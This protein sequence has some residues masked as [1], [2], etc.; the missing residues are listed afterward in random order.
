MR[1]YEKPPIKADWLF[2]IC[3]ASISLM[4]FSYRAAIVSALSLF[5]YLAINRLIFK[6]TVTM[7]LAIGY[8]L[9]STLVMLAAS[10]GSIH[11][12]YVLKYL[13]ISTLFWLLLAYLPAIGYPQLSRSLHQFI[14]IHAFFFI[15]Q[16]A[17]NAATG[18]LID[19]NNLVREDH[20]NTISGSRSLEGLRIGIRAG[21]LFSEPSFYSMTVFPVALLLCLHERQLSLSV[22]LGMLTSFLSLSVAGMMITVT[23]TCLALLSTKGQLRIKVALGGLLAALIPLGMKIYERRITDSIDYDAVGSRMQV[24]EQIKSQSLTKTFL[25]NGLFWDESTTIGWTGLS[26]YHVRDSSFYVYVLF[27]SGI[28]GLCLFLMLLI[29]ALYRAPRILCAVLLILLYKYGILVSSLWLSLAIAMAY[30]NGCMN[31][32]FPRPNNKIRQQTYA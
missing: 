2:G 22:V 9:T 7:R 29:L 14:F 19:F 17:W 18:D 24:F 30:A 20:A 10:R 27:T 23:G 26:A 12:P 1:I 6:P 5:A 25:G 31:N 8:L 16:L 3:L 13:G 15:F 28:V 21:G 4:T 32:H 11:P